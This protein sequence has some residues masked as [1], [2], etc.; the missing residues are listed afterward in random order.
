MV[1]K[2]GLKIQP[3]QRPPGPADDF[4]Q[5]ARGRM[6]ALMV[7]MSGLALT[8]S[9]TLGRQVIDRTGLDGRYDFQ[10]AF[11]PDDAAATDRPSIYAA[12]QE[13]LGLRLN[14]SKGPV[15]VLV[16][17]RAELPAAN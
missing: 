12:L 16:I 17:D 3:A 13:Q 14:A 7:K 5:T 6:K 10:L 15:K 1:A 2:G 11:A 4:I 9:G 8:L